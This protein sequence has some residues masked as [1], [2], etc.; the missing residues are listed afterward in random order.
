MSHK[1]ILKDI[2]IVVII[3][4]VLALL[5]GLPFLIENKRSSTPQKYDDLAMCLSE[6]N[7]IFYGAFW[8]PRCAEQKLHFGR[9]AKLLPYIECSTPDGNDQLEICQNEGITSYPTWKFNNEERVCRGLVSRYLV[10][11]QSGCEAHISEEE[12]TPEAIWNVY[13]EELKLERLHG[14]TLSEFAQ[15]NFQ[16]EVS[17]ITP[18]ELVS[19]VEFVSCLSDEEINLIRQFQLQ[20]VEAETT[21]EGDLEVN[22][23]D[24][25]GNPIEIQV[26]N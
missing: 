13:T 7:A 12:Y 25:N 26:E 3:I 5:F 21:G 8:C 18:Q 4:L 9:S 24:E 2:I 1:S 15:E 20:Q 11:Q 17:E 23:T 6:Q 19:T 22:L 16:K 14:I 10:A